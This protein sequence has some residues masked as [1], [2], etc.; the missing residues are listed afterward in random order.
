MRTDGIITLLT[1][2]LAILIQLNTV[3]SD[4]KTNYIVEKA[5][6]TIKVIEAVITAYTSLPE[7][8]D[9]TPFITA[10]VATTREGII[11]CPRKYRFGARFVIEGKV[12]DCQDRMNIRYEG[13]E[14]EHFDIW[15]PSYEEAKNYGVHRRP[16]I[17]YI[18]PF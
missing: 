4:Y 11:A 1:S 2:F 8:T 7:L 10:S 3:L 16:I 6:V 9:S 12:Y 18:V 5:G 13:R 15:F 17:R 14:K